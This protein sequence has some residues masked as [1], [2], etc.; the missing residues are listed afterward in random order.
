MPAKGKTKLSDRQRAVIAVRKAE[1]KTHDEIGRE[2][3]L[4]PSTVKKSAIDPRTQNIIRELKATHYG[5][6]LALYKK[7]LGVLDKL[8]D[9]PDPNLR[10]RAVKVLADV[11]SAGEV[12]TVRVVQQV[13]LPPPE[14]PS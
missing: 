11:L 4:H 8:L 14:Q 2:L 10:L 7:G 13:A 12:S 9:D 3:A 1:G 5:E 6:L